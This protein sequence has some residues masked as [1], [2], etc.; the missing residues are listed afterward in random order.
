MSNA[1]QQCARSRLK[2]NSQMLKI[3]SSSSSS[4]SSISS[5]SKKIGSIE[6]LRKKMR[7]AVLPVHESSVR[8]RTRYSTSVLTAKWALNVDDKVGY[9]RK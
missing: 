6:K 1:R 5:S 2:D 7:P 8:D 3:S 4:S 9:Q